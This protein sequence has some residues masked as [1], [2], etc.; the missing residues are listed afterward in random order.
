MLVMTSVVAVQALLFQDGGLIALGA[1]VL[2]MAVIACLVGYG[3]Y[4]V[5]QRLLGG[6]PWANLAGAFVAAWLSV[7][8]TALACALQLSLS[9]S[10]P[11]Q[12]ALPAMGAVHV[13]IGVGEGLITVAAVAFISA[14]RR[15]LVQSRS[16]SN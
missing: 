11:I 5:A 7:F 15:D 14:T 2:N 12:V 1:N 4:V 13:L 16:A 9:G 10:S 3:G 6:R 8:V